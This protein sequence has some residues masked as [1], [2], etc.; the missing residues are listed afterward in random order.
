MALRGER[1]A[2]LR[3]AA[4]GGARAVAPLRRAASSRAGVVT[5]VCAL[6]VASAVVAAWPAV[7]HADDRFLSGGAPG[8]GEAAAGDHL[9]TGYRLWLVGHQLEHGRAP[10]LDPY[11]FR[12]ELE[13]QP[14]PGGWPFG[15][16]YWPL[17]AALGAVGAWNAFTLLAYL[18]AGAAA[19]LW[20]RELDL[21]RGPALAGGLA[22]AIA[23]YRVQQSAGHLLGPIALLLP[24][25]LW[26]WERGRRGSK[27][28]H[29]GA[30]ASIASIPLSGQ[31]HLALGAIPFFA[32]YA[33]CRTRSPRALAGAAVGVVAAVAAGLIVQRAVISH[34][35]TGGHRTLAEVTFY[36]ADWQDLLTRHKRH[37]PESFV[38]VGWLVPLLAVAGLVALRRRALG[39]ALGL[40][41]A[42]PMLF[43]LGTNLPWYSWLWHH[44]PLARYPRVPERLMPVACLAVA[45]LAAVAFDRL[46]VPALIAV[47]LV[48][49]DLHVRVYGASAADRDNRAYAAIT[50]PGRILELPVLTP[51]IHLGSVYFL[52]DQR[53]AQRERPGG[54][55]TLAPPI[56]DQTARRLQWLNTGDWSH[57][58]QGRLRELGVR[59]VAVHDGIY[60]QV[61]RLGPEAGV[62]A[63]RGL[64]RNGWRLLSRDG[65]ISIYTLRS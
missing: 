36:S 25:A 26:C 63:K 23:P 22:F 3:R 12:P 61:K 16:P 17:Y 52:Y 19:Y 34:S 45:A 41:A 38:F 47:L 7:K 8:H 21:R 14:N 54:Y 43:A 10:W 29:L 55:S 5:A 31:V 20:L 33:L 53:A 42:L 6:Y 1:G 35:L 62:Q 15:L 44:V 58:G 24:L 4:A 46:R 51:D 49:V 9:Q 11:T 50:E 18:T 56:A 59:F 27:W 2:G 32:G 65:V 30:A 60:E 64:V 48:T 40:G 39:L 13:P 28:W 37:G 57:D